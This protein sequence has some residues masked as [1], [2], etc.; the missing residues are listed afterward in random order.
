VI[1]TPVCGINKSDFFPG[2]NP[3]T[4]IIPS[5]K[6]IRQAYK[7]TPILSSWHQAQENRLYKISKSVCT[8]VYYY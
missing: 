8:F 5:L 7:I 4:Y 2:P 6:L 3:H 1:I